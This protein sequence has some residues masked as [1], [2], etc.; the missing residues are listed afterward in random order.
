MIKISP[1]L[2]KNKDINALS[3]LVKEIKEGKNQW[4]IDVESNRHDLAVDLVAELAGLIDISSIITKFFIIGYVASPS[5]F[6]AVTNTSILTAMAVENTDKN[7]VWKTIKVVL[8]EAKDKG[9]NFCS[10]IRGWDKKCALG[11]A[12]GDQLIRILLARINETMQNPD[13]WEVFKILVMD[14]LYE[15]P[16]AYKTRLAVLEN[17][18]VVRAEQEHIKFLK[19]LPALIKATI[20][21]LNSDNYDSEKRLFYQNI[22]LWKSKLISLVSLGQEIANPWIL[23]TN[24]SLSYTLHSF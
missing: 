7:H 5:A 21:P 14:H 19:G 22:N 3:R 17:Q 2:I 8:E 10:L 20:A 18:N 4:A 23:K 6:N 12:Q 13:M 11:E 9:V 1:Q 16:D 24:F 15:R